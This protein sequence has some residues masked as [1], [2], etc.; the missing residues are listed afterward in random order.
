MEGMLIEGFNCTTY[1]RVGVCTQAKKDNE[2][3]GR[4]PYL[5]NELHNS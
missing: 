3:E 1:Q 2:L 5:E 4:S